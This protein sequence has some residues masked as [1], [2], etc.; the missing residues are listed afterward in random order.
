MATLTQLPSAAAQSKAPSPSNVGTMCL[1]AGISIAFVSYPSAFSEGPEA[2]AAIAARF[3]GIGFLLSVFFDAMQGIRN[4]YRVDLLCIFAI[5]GLTL[6]EFLFPQEV[7]TD[8]TTPEETSLSISIV[9]VGM[10][11]LSIGRHLVPPKPIK[12]KFLTLADISNDS[13]F[14][15]VV[16]SGFFG[17]LYMLMNVE[18]SIFKM[19]DA[20]MGARF[21]QPWGRGRLGGINTL[22]IELKML[23]YIVPPL[24]AVAWTRIK[25][26][27]IS[28]FMII[29][30]ICAL[31][32]FDAIA[33]GSRNIYIAHI[34]TLL[35]AY[36][37]VRPKNTMINTI[38]PIMLTV[39]IS[40]FISYHML[41]FRTMG[42]RTYLDN[43]IYATDQ[44]RDSFAADY[45]LASIGWV[46]SQM[47]DPYPFLGWEVVTWSLIKPIPRAF[48]PGKPEGLSVSIEE[49]AGA[50]GW[51]IAVTYLGEAYMSFGMLGVVGVSLFLGALAAWWNRMVVVGQ[52]DYA[53]VVYALGFFA[54]GITMRSMFWL[55]TAMLPVIALIVFRKYGGLK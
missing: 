21:T 38:V 24:T 16:F 7:F 34:S 17:F 3:V 1:L 27:S 55:T 26:F 46:A 42:M 20:M 36:L 44:V 28:Q 47:P 19:I 31:V 10:F 50:T 32:F 6:L 15:I 22:I 35:M 39:W 13:I 11:F 41:E 12:S 25:K 49:I 33:G 52:S 40:G 2:M 51:T 53:L 45:N 54:A 30:L 18:F 4:L 29:N 14:K 43:K 23:T 9:L 5:Y 48:L 37:I 8:M